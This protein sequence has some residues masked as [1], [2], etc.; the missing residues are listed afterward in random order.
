M[1]DNSEEKPEEKNSWAHKQELGFGPI[2]GAL[3]QTRESVKAT[4]NSLQIEMERH[5]A[6][7]TRLKGR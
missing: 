7:L 6:A 4:I 3:I 1:M 2:K 5:K